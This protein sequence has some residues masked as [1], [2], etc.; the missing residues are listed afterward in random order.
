VPVKLLFTTDTNEFPQVFRVGTHWIALASES[1]PVGF[2]FR[3][4]SPGTIVLSH[5]KKAGIATSSSIRTDDQGVDLHSVW[6]CEIPFDVRR[7]SARPPVLYPGNIIAWIGHFR[8]RLPI[9]RTTVS[10][11]IG[12]VKSGTVRVA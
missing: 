1:G 6:V 7:N 4:E 12:Q 11:M 10:E 3:R 8:N 2:R 5:S 9:G